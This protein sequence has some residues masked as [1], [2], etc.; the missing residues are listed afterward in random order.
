[1]YLD[2]EMS[3]WQFYGNTIMNSTTG[4]VI[5]G[6]RRNVIANNTFINCDLDIH[7][8]NAA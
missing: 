2:D 7:F 6:G 5:G 1:M 8:D 3:G 4:L